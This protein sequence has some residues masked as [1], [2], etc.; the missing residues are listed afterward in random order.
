[1]AR[2]QLILAYDGTELEG[3]Q[4]QGSKRTVQGVVEQALRSLN[5]D[6]R[7]LLAAGRTDSGVHD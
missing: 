3:F 4:R 6:G 2:Y 1:M 5:W 7:A